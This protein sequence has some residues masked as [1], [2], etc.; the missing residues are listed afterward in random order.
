MRL[1]QLCCSVQLKHLFVCC[2]VV[3][4]P[5]PRWLCMCW[6]SLPMPPHRPLPMRR[7]CAKVPSLVLSFS[8]VCHWV[9]VLCIA[10][11]DLTRMA[12]V[13]VLPLP[14][15]PKATASDCASLCPAAAARRCCALWPP[16]RGQSHSTQTHGRCLS[17]HWPQCTTARR[18]RYAWSQSVSVGVRSDCGCVQVAA[19]GSNGVLALPAVLQPCLLRLV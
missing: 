12:Q 15:C 11:Y 17:R 10:L 4:R 19:A 2:V 8:R 5:C 1:P 16:L 9:F 7:A 13:S 6:L 18:S 3:P 14:L